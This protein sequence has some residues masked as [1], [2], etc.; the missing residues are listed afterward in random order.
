MVPPGARS[1]RGDLMP[2]AQDSARIET[3]KVLVMLRDALDQPPLPAQPRLA[4]EL[5]LDLLG[6]GDVARRVAT[7]DRL[8]AMLAALDGEPS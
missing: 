7:R 3:R 6:E 8:T 1:T 5:V 4:V 2:K